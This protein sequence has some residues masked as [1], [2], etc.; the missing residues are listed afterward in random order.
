MSAKTENAG[1]LS[2]RIMRFSHKIKRNNNY[3]PTGTTIKLIDQNGD[4]I[5]KVSARDF[6]ATASAA[7]DIAE[8][9]K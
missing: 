1:T 2:A 3:G 7:L 6:C 4:V 9:A 5:C 8:A